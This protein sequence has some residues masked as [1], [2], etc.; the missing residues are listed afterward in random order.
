MEEH[1]EYVYDRKIS[2]AKLK[3]RLKFQCGLVRKPSRQIDAQQYRCIGENRY[4]TQNTECFRDVNVFTG[5]Y[6][7]VENIA[8]I[9]W[10]NANRGYAMKM[11][12]ICVIDWRAGLKDL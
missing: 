6:Y 9:H 12:R 2:L 8:R 5:R 11:M 10:E 3:W 4:A 1:S 7:V